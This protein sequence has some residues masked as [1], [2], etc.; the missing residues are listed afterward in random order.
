MPRP[1]MKVYKLRAN[2]GKKYT[3]GERNLISLH[4]KVERHSEDWRKSIWTSVLCSICL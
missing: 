2:I 1:I 3:L 4:L